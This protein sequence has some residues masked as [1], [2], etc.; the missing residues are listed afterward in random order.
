MKGRILSI[1]IGEKHLGYTTLDLE[2]MEFNS[3]I[4]TVLEKRGS[5]IVLER[6]S[7]LH[8]F[9]NEVAV[10]GLYAAVIERQVV[11]NEIAMEL[12]YSLVS[13]IMPYTN[14]ICIFDPKRKFTTINQPYITT[15]KKHKKLSIENMRKIIATNKFPS[16]AKLSSILESE[17]KKDD[18]ADSFNQLLIYLIDLKID[19]FSIDEIKSLVL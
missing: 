14:R 2:T 19:C 15:G 3:G 1:D 18:I 12:M 4:Y 10:N 8:K 17:P 16:F 5:N 9:I 6:V 7:S 11:G 13:L